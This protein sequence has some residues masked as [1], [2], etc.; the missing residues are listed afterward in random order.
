[1]QRL[2]ERDLQNQIKKEKRLSTTTF[3]TDGGW[4]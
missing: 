4:W 2:D 1:M 3:P